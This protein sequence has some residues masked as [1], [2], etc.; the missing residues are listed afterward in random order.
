MGCLTRIMRGPGPTSDC[1]W[2]ILSPAADSTSTFSTD[3]ALQA[4]TFQDPRD[5]EFLFALLSSEFESDIG[6]AKVEG[7]TLTTTVRMTIA[8]QVQEYLTGFVARRGQP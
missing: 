1:L 7:K 8:K 6:C 2:S 4:A 5:H 3:R